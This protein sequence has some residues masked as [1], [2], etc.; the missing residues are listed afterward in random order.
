MRRPVSMMIRPAGCSVMGKPLTKEGAQDSTNPVADSAKTKFGKLVRQGTQGLA[1]KGIKSL[2]GSLIPQDKTFEQMD[3][4]DEQWFSVPSHRFIVHPNGSFR[5]FWDM[6]ALLA[7][8]M[9]AVNIPLA[10]CFEIDSPVSLQWTLTCF[11]AFDVVLNFFTGYFYDG[12]LVMKQ[13]HL[14]FHYLTGW[15]WIDLLSTIP[16]SFLFT[17]Y[18]STSHA[19]RFA[20]IGRGLKMLRMLRIAKLNMLVGRLEEVFHSSM[21]VIFLALGKI[22]SMFLLLCHW[23]ACFWGWLGHPDRQDYPRSDSPLDKSN[24]EPGGPCESSLDGSPWR[25]RYGVELDDLWS[26]YLLALRFAAGM[27]TGNDME[28]QAGYWAERF[29]V[30]FIMFVSF[31][32]CSTVVSKIIIVFHKINQEQAEQTELIQ[33]FR[34]FMGHGQVPL[35]LQAK[36]RRYLE[37]QFRSRKDPSIRRFEMMERLSPWLRQE[38]Q[39]HMNKGVLLMHP[40]FKHMQKEL[41]LYAC[42]NAETVLCAPGDIIMQYG[43]VAHTVCFAI[44]GKLQVK[45]LIEPSNNGGGGGRSSLLM[46]KQEVARTQGVL[47]TSPAYIGAASIF[48]EEVRQYSVISVTHSELLTLDKEVIDALGKQFPSA[49]Q[50]VREYIAAAESSDAGFKDCSVREAVE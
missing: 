47:L 42:C 34:E 12:V 22:V 35:P 16:W 21:L 31:I 37:F 44:R 5:L 9:E 11:L 23:C 25:R 17:D 14:V 50:Y 43:Q 24:C 40:F 3:L 38:L 8:V 26:Q 10:L 19:A 48:R 39:E 33:S 49:L 2:E 28:L 7:I 27:F 29:Y 18:G 15:F 36:V 1:V 6:F 45:K 32:V 46:L 13:Y 41:L 4:V 30:V 20:K